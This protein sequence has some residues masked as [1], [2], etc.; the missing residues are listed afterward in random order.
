M[1]SDPSDGVAPSASS[2]VTP[3]ASNGVA[4]S[5][6]NGIAPSTS[7]GV[8]PSASNA[9]A[10]SAG[11]AA[12]LPPILIA[13]NDPDDL[14][15]TMHLVKR[16][17][18]AHPVITFDDGAAVV[19]YLSRAWLKRPEERGQLPRLLF[20][21]LKMSGLGGF[22]FLEWIAKHP[23]LAAIRVVVLSGSDEPRDIERAKALG[24][25]RY[26]AK[27]PCAATFARIIAHVYGESAVA[28]GTARGKR[29]TCDFF[30]E[31][32]IASE[33]NMRR[34]RVPRTPD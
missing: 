17:G 11:R 26:L 5:A 20:L 15:F 12:G 23:E 30:E 4:P 8:A 27:H 16:S 6:S 13:D 1:S 24:A 34:Q 28:P 19:D 22:A 3:S 14:Y 9:V 31:S 7:N 2:G 18:T 10:P 33:H 32:V 21:D 29:A 25:K